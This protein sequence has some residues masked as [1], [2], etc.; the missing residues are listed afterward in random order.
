VGISSQV[1][2]CESAQ[3]KDPRERVEKDLSCEIVGTGLVNIVD[4]MHSVVADTTSY[5]GKQ[6]RIW[7]CGHQEE[8]FYIWQ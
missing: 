1:V 5:G 7:I 6:R 2:A 3:Q 4:N 8:E